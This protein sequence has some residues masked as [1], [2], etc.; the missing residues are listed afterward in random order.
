MNRIIG[1]PLLLALTLPVQAQ[2]QFPVGKSYKA[3]S[4]S[5]FDVQNKGLSMTVSG[6]PKGDMR[7]SGSAGC[8]SW[9]ATVILRDEQLDFTSIVTTRKLCAKPTMTA[10]DAFRSSLRSAKRWRIDGDK[11]IIEG[12][13][14]SLMLKP[15]LAELKSEKPPKRPRPAR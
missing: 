4:I 8:N 15:G 5:G 3:I 1:L 10:E 14:A 12:D 11:L 6:D 9:N 13:A 7:G 2:S